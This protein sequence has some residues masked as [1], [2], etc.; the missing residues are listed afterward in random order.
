MPTTIT[1]N[2]SHAIYMSIIVNMAPLMIFMI[3][4]TPTHLLQWVYML[5]R[6]RLFY[7]IY[8]RER[9]GR[10]VDK[11]HRN[12]TEVYDEL[13]PWS[14]NAYMYMYVYT[15]NDDSSL[16]TNLSKETLWPLHKESSSEKLSWIFFCFYG[17]VFYTR[18]LW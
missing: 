11:F 13:L 18:S 12:S 16:L 5:Y 6:G 10:K 4:D 9:H 15:D 1:T 2:S 7:G 8:H 14:N 17:H 3:V